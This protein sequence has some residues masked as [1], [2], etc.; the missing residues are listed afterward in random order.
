MYECQNLPVMDRLG[1]AER[2]Q[3]G[4]APGEESYQRYF[5]FTWKCCFGVLPQ[6]PVNDM[7]TPGGTPPT[8]GDTLQLQVV[9]TSLYSMCEGEGYH[10]SE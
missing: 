4:V 6:L 2:F 10:L 1:R 8:D 9:V 3:L 5:P 7:D